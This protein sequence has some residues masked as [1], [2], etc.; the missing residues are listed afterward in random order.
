MNHSN[1]DIFEGVSIFFWE[2]DTNSGRKIFRPMKMLVFAM[3]IMF[4]TLRVGGKI[5]QVG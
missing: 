5:L 4:L 2:G 1:Y 3:I